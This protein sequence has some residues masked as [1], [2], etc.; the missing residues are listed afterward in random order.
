MKNENELD[1]L[2][3]A[4][5]HKEYAPT[6]HLNQS[7][8]HNIREQEGIVPFDDNRK[9]GYKS[10]IKKFAKAAAVV[11]LLSCAGYIG[12]GAAGY[13]KPIS[14]IFQ[15]IFHSDEQDKDLVNSM[16]DMIG[17]TQLHDGVKITQEAVIA[18]GEVYAFVFDIEKE[19]GTA[20]DFA[21]EMF[22][23]TNTPS[24]W[25][26]FDSTEEHTSLSEG[27][28]EC[29]SSF[30]FYDDDPADACIQLIIICQLRRTRKDDLFTQRFTNLE[31][32]DVKKDASSVIAKG[33]WEFTTQLNLEDMS[34]V[35]FENQNATIGTLS[36]TEGTCV[37]SP[38]KYSMEFTIS[39]EEYMKN[40][41][42]KDDAQ[43]VPG[44]Y[45]LSEDIRKQGIYLN[46]KDGEK[47][48]ISKQASTGLRLDDEKEKGTLSIHDIF[49]RI[50]P[51]ENIE[52]ISIGNQTF[53][54]QKI[55]G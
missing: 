10:S 3:K 6:E 50:V 14:E 15:S 11:I 5:Y 12:A 48:N 29:D 22:K 38:I 35:V 45:S 27:T 32:Y 25:L 33:T 44:T 52:S 2:L 42:K 31:L 40:Y 18:D 36:A 23:E 34:R 16:G 21:K 46:L 54:M 24:M 43:A 49:D 4:T 41:K 47:I 51:I 13:A 30:R 9:T 19:D 39:R 55:S 26:R 28:A 53:E 7:V 20:F 1:K 8:L 37:I 17:S